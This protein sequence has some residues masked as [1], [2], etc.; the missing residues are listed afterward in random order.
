MIGTL[1]LL[2]FTRVPGY[3]IVFAGL[4]SGFAYD[5]LGLHQMVSGIDINPFLF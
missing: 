3:L 2:Y 5:Y 1:L 4:L